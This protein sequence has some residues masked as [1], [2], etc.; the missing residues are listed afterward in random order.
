MELQEILAILHAVRDTGVAELD[1][2]RGDFK[3]T[4]R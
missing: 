4:I 1:L 2:A 3:L